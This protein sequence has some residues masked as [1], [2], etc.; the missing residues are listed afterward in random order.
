[1][2]KELPDQYRFSA[3]TIR[4]YYDAGTVGTCIGFEVTRV[5]ENHDALP[6]WDAMHVTGAMQFFKVARVLT[7]QLPVF[8]VFARKMGHSSA[9]DV[10]RSR[11]TQRE[12]YQIHAAQDPT[13]TL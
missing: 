2:F 4:R 13:Y 7:T 11:D 10:V 5:L 3:P 9:L 1:M 12:K 8:N 6:D